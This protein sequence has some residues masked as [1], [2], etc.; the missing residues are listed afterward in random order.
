MLLMGFLEVVGGTTR[1]VAETTTLQSS[2]PLFGAMFSS[3][4]V[5][6]LANAA[7]LVSAA[8]H[9]A[10]ADF[11]CP[12]DEMQA[13]QCLGARDCLYAYPN[14][15][16]KFIY[17]ELSAD[18]NSA[19]KLLKD[20]PNGLLWKDTEKICAFPWESTCEGVAISVGVGLPR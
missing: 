10:R 12:L 4:A 7:L 8:P 15:C 13:N 16:S 5:V 14:D 9:V 19:K 20:C 18:G 2:I 1:D 11:V 17:C 6:L 3:L